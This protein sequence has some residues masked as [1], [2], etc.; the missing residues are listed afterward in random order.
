V[1]LERGPLSPVSTTEELP[2]GKSRYS[3]LENLD[4]G[5]EDPPR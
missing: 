2:E 1:G 5:L 4:Y 3:G